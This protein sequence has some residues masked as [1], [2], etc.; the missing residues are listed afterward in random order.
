MGGH[1]LHDFNK[2]LEQSLKVSGR[3]FSNRAE[4]VTASG[5]RGTVM[6]GRVLTYMQGPMACESGRQQE[7]WRVGGENRVAKQANSEKPDMWTGMPAHTHPRRYGQRLGAPET[8]VF[9][10]EWKRGCLGTGGP[11]PRTWP[12][13]KLGQC[14]QVLRQPSLLFV[15]NNNG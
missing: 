1:L 6:G 12:I 8:S 5:S 9:I 10:L 4:E 2:F 3:E 15:F 11:S 14:V 7:K 13:N